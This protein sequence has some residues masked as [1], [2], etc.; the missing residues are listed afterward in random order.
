MATIVQYE[1]ICETFLVSIYKIDERNVYNSEI[2]CTKKCEMGDEFRMIN[3]EK[4]YHD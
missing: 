1:N 2:A 3:W 4:H